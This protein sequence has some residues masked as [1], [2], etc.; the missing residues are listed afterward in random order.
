M[1][2]PREVIVVPH[3]HWD[4]EW[5]SPFQTF[6]LK[7]VD[8]VDDLLDLLERDPSYTHFMLDGQVAVV[9]DYLAVRPENEHRLRRLASAGRLGMGPWYILMDEFLV[10][11]ETMIR[12]LQ[13]GFEKAA[14][15]G[16]AMPV[17]YLPDMFGHIAQMPQLLQQFGLEHAVVWRGVPSAI[18]KGSFSWEAPDGSS[19]R[20]EY[21][22]EGYGN[23]AALPDDAKELLGLVE[24]FE[25][26]YGSFL[27]GPLLWMNGTDHQLPAPYLG[28][29]LAEANDLQDDYSFRVG[30]LPEYLSIAPP[31]ELSWRGELRSG[32]RANLLM[33]VTS[34]RVDVKQAAAVAE[35]S[36]ERLAEPL[37]ALYL[38]AARWPQRLLSEA[39][40]EMVRNSAHDSS[41]ACSVD[42]VVDAV[43]HRYAEARQI[44]EGLTE[45]AV[46]ALGDSLASSGGLVVNASSR[47]R[48]G[49][50]ELT[51]PGTEPVAGTQVLKVSSGRAGADGITR[52]DAVTLTQ[53]A[54]DGM[55]ELRDVEIEVDDDGVLDVKLHCAFEDDQGSRYSGSAKSLV[56]EAAGQDP[57]GPARIAIVTPPSQRV[58]TWVE[59][60]D[61]FGWALVEAGAGR[62][63][64]VEVSGAD[65]A[66]T[67]TNGRITVV[68]DPVS[69]TFSLDGVEGLGRLVDD[70]DTGDT[71]NYSPPNKDLVVDTPDSVA[72]KVVERGPL[73][74]RVVVERVY[75]WPERAFFGERSGERT[76]PITTTIDVVAGSP[77]VR[78]TTELD[79]PSR[80]HRL[81]AWFP[82]PQP[83]ATSVAECAFATVERGLDAEGG[84]NE[85][86]LPTYPSRRFVCAGGLTIVHEG[87]LEYELVDRDD[88]GAHALALTLLRCTGLLSNGP[89]AYRPLPAG[90][91]VPADDAQMIGSQVLRYGVQPGDDTGAAYAA[92][93]D[94]F[95][96]MIVA[97]APGGGDRPDRGHALSVTGAEVSAVLRDAGQLVVRVFNPS[98]EPTTVRIEG[99]QGWLTDLRGRPVEPFEQSFEL[100]PWRIATAQ[101]TRT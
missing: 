37:S 14:A 68:I 1:E 93:D 35:R 94:A 17:G 85:R 46:R 27:S 23:G 80:D 50:V 63:P 64:P 88:D 86:A 47:A 28:R 20:A 97:R 95:L 75:T 78:V 44:G 81:R 45:R 91:F 12:D 36:L 71:Y 96:P 18:D 74:A 31:A 43:L 89:M 48:S 25:H 76:V 84:P 7:L 98:P 90:P 33:G 11:G 101:L 56:S 58:L 39:W 30:S 77:L 65:D 49:V 82:L 87:L 62:V 99:E 73:R 5:Y 8:L 3:T 32:A 52:A 9:D 34:N 69:G 55:Q 60:V 41:C 67:I 10:S 2:A 100:G 42:E 72:V 54:I 6:R 61:G 13:L 24:R 79:N 92:V 70:G 21:L 16:G 66:P 53:A 19:V 29:V 15:F 57:S 4:R 26:D 40:L 51:L 59:S 83:A 22:L 38:P